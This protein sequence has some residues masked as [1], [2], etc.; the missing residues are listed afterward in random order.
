MKAVDDPDQGVAAYRYHELFATFLQRRLIEEHPERLSI[1][2]QR[3]GLAHSDASQQ[4]RH[5]IAAKLPEQAA[6]S[7]ESICRFEL[8][9]R[10]ISHQTRALIMT[11]PE[12]VRGKRVWLLITLGSYHAQRGQYVDAASYFKQAKALIQSSGD[13]AAEIELLFDVAWMEGAAGDDLMSAMATKLATVP[14][15]ITPAQKASFHCAS[16]W[17]YCQI[18]DWPNATDHIRAGIN[19]VLQSSDQGTTSIVVQALGPELIFNDGG[20]ATFKPLMDYLSVRTVSDNWPMLLNLHL[21]GGWI[22]YFQGRPDAAE[23]KSR[24]AQKIIDQ[25]GPMGWP[26]GHVACLELT[27]LR[28]QKQFAHM[29]DRIEI[30]LQ[31]LPSDNVA[32]Y[33]KEY[34]LYLQGQAAILQNQMDVAKNSLERL[35]ALEFQSYFG[36]Q[37]QE[38]AAL[39]EGQICI[40]ETR[41]VVG[42]E[43]LSQAAEMQ[44]QV[45]HTVW[46]PHPRI[47]L[48]RLYQL[49]NQPDRALSELRS[50]LAEVVHFQAPGMLLQEGPTIV[51]LLRLAVERRLQP[52]LVE[53]VLALYN[54]TEDHPPA[55]IIPGRAES[56]SPREMEVLRLLDVGASNHAIAETLFI[57]LRTVKAHVSSI[58]AKLGVKSRGEAVARS[59]DLHLL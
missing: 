35:K 8:G 44:C 13:E 34:F 33:F 50:V 12:N 29:M 2:H 28:W 49:Q 56:L 41:W 37:T 16:E 24:V 14:H 48:A 59:H 20:L 15:L 18:G 30:I 23:N 42:E 9:Q 36:V 38:L 53:P 43:L 47:S 52:D 31:G 17:R 46:N 11:L 25:I 6:N 51:P 22:Q 5:L 55:V 57:T 1:L 54:Q 7:L 19:L 4:V 45:R 3:A 10:N 40:A 27:L 21:M 39:L 26:D 58:L 32:G